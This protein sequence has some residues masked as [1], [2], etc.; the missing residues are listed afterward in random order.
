MRKSSNFIF[1]ICG[2]FFMVI[3]FLAED[4]AFA[5]AIGG[6]SIALF[7]FYTFSDQRKEQKNKMESA[8]TKQTESQPEQADLSKSK[9]LEIKREEEPKSTLKPC[10]DIKQMVVK[11]Q[12]AFEY[13]YDELPKMNFS[14][15]R[16]N[17][18]SEDAFV[19][20]ELSEEEIDKLREMSRTFWAG[21]SHIL[22]ESSGNLEQDRYVGMLCLYEYIRSWRGYGYSFFANTNVKH[23]LLEYCYDEKNGYCYDG[24]CCGEEITYYYLCIKR[25]SS[26]ELE[27]EFRKKWNTYHSS[28]IPKRLGFQGDLPGTDCMAF[29]TRSELW[30]K[31]PFGLADGFYIYTKNY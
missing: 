6:I 18:D 1:L 14:E 9:P 12:T 17:C 24:G 15:L 7:V 20:P 11:R 16:E 30:L 2:I 22:Q 13:S 5:F 29:Y 27:I 3:G 28:E 21:D 23:G 10:D 31:Q 4:L 8:E 19:I 25:I 26:N